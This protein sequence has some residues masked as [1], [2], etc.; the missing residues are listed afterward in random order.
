MSR[1]P[2][3]EP[4]RHSRISG[5][6]VYRPRRRVP[7]SE[8]VERIDSS[9]EW[10]RSRSGILERRWSE[11]DET[12]TM[13]S[14]EASRGALD[15]AGLTPGDID[16]V[17]VATFTH[18][19]QTPSA[20]TLVADALGSTPAGAFDLSAACAGFSYGI[21]VASDLVRCGTAQHVLV[22][23][24][25]RMSSLLDLDDRGT[26]FIFG[27]GAGAVIVSSSDTPQIGPTVWGSDGSQAA[28]ITSRQPWDEAFAADEPIWPAL[29]M[30]GNPVYRWASYEM[31]A[32]A[33]QTLK[34]TGL[35]VDD[36][37][38]FI[39][40]QANMRITDV[41]ARRLGLP[42]RVAIARDIATQG[43]TSAASIPLAMDR[44]RQDGETKPGD[45]ALL[46]GFGA[47]LAYAAQIVALP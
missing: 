8:L 23:G 29:T 41:M 19:M 10:I 7:N 46:I 30:D 25:E 3:P 47:G 32:V 12:L 36:L 37:D 21:G 22:I 5:L 33:E 20:A 43:N 34:T 40:H 15:E 38:A 24:A 42:D 28:L 4:T 39:P 26:A 45:L 1:L 2:A 13:M 14:V 27:D 11:D 44:L 35:S 6:G 9:D 31:A 17:L 18:L 16:L